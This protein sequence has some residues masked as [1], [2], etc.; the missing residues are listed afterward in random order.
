[1]AVR[2]AAVVARILA[3]ALV[4]LIAPRAQAASAADITGTVTLNG[5]PP[6]EQVNTH[7]ASDPICGKL[8]PEPVK[9][10]FF[11]VGPKGELKDVLE[12]E[13]FRNVLATGAEAI[14]ARREYRE[15]NHANADPE[16]RP[17]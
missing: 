1:M 17:E 6:P 4:G 2:R 10:Q 3:L 12:D 15:A 13:T 8:H 9:T 16:S 7:I 14:F 5:T 11:V